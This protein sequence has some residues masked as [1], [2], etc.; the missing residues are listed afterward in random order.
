MEFFFPAAHSQ[1]DWTKGLIFL[2]KELQ[3]VTADAEIGRRYA[4]KLVKVYLING[5]EEWILIH[6]EVQ[7]QEEDD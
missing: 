3:E 5:K 1:I 4:N 2:D 7:S 6:V